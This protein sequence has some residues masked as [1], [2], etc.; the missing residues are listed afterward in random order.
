MI[1]ICQKNILCCGCPDMDSC[2]KQKQEELYKKLFSKYGNY[3]KEYNTTQFY[4]SCDHPEK[5]E[6]ESDV[7]KWLHH[8]DQDIEKLELYIARLQAYKM[9][10]IKRYNYIL[11][12]P[13]KEKI[14]LQR[15]KKY[16]GNV[17]YYIIFYLVDLE[18][19]T[20]KETNR[21][22]YKGTERKQAFTDFD[23]ICKEHKNAIIEKDIE[24][25]NWEK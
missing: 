24:K 17:F 22:T 21:I 9:E 23:K 25:K 16:Q 20:E 2:T 19:G 6:T 8:A 7:L 10:L 12:R 1:E 15:H 5:M 4:I 3:I 14:L 18:T 11:T 13:T